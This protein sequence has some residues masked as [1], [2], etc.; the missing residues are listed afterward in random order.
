MTTITKFTNPDVRAL[1]AEF[2]AAIDAVAAKYGLKGNLGNIRYDNDELRVKLTVNTTV[3]NVNNGAANGVTQQR[4]NEIN[5]RG[6]LLCG[7]DDLANK[8]LR[9]EGRTVVIVDFKNRAKRYPF[10]AEDI[11]TG[12]KYKL[13]ADYIRSRYLSPM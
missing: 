9:V 13:S 4:V 5:F 12:D 2:Q 1:R 6:K 7:I 8:Q 3:T 11:K 10:I